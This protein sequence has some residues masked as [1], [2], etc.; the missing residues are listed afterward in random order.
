[1]MNSEAAWAQLDTGCDHPVVAVLDSGWV[2]ST[3]HAEYNL[4]PKSAWFNA[5][6]TTQGNADSVVTDP[7]LVNG[8]NHGTAV[9]GVIAMTTN[10]YGAGAGVAYNLAKVLPITVMSSDSYING[11]LNFVEVPSSLA[12]YWLIPLDGVNYNGS[13]VPDLGTVNAAIDTGTTLIGGPQA[14]VSS[15]YQRIPGAQSA[16][17]NYAGY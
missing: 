15:L 14:F 17:G 13:A 8:R 11:T 3:T 10:G 4:V 2:G 12:S 6:T 7:A 16:G 9:A 1:M 5:I